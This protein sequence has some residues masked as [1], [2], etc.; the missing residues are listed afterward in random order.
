MLNEELEHTMLTQRV[1]LPVAPPDPGLGLLLSEHRVTRVRAWGN[2]IGGWVTIILGLVSL[3]V[4]NFLV[5]RNVPA[6]PI[7]GGFSL[8]V[9]LGGVWSVWTQQ[10]EKSLAV[11][12]YQAGLV[13]V[14][15][16]KTQM[17]RWA[18][19]S[20]V[21]LAT[22]YNRKLQMTSHNYK[23]H[24]RR[25]S[26]L[27]FNFNDQAMSDL[28]QLS[29]TLQR[30][31]TARLLP[32]AIAAVQAG[33]PLVFGRLTVGQAGLSLGRRSLPW[34]EVAS[35]QLEQGFV[36]IRRRSQKGEWGRTA[37]AGVPNIFVFTGLVDFIL[38]QASLLSEER[39]V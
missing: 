19:I 29:A 6:L 34:P 7:C 18:E 26:T 17:V 31:V 20:Q 33:Q 39:Q 24:T 3:A 22:Y 38:N 35:V 25:G 9:L 32:E 1:R 12:L 27:A 21:Q 8:A 14:R 5:L 10:R 28:A 4:T 30:E 13:Y 36:V 15:G 11:R 2:L 16:E 37:V 23:L